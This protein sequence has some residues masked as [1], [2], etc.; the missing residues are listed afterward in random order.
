MARAQVYRGNPE[1]KQT[2]IFDN[3][4]GGINTTSIDEQV[5]TNEFRKLKNV[6][7]KE[8]GRIQNR[9]GFANVLGV[10]KNLDF[11][12]PNNKYY[13]LDIVEDTYNEIGKLLD[14]NYIMIGRITIDAVYVKN[15]NVHI[16]RYVIGNNEGTNTVLSEEDHLIVEGSETVIKEPK[17]TG[18]NVMN[19]D[20][21]NYFLINEILD[22]YEGFVEWGELDSEGK[23]IEPT[24]Y[25]KENSYMPNIYDVLGIGTNVFSNNPQLHISESNTS[26]QNIIYVNL[27]EY[28]NELNNIDKIPNNGKFTIEVYSTGT[29]IEEGLTLNFYH[30]VG[31]DKRPINAVISD[32]YKQNG[33]LYY[34]VELIDMPTDKLIFL[35]IKKEIEYDNIPEEYT[36]DKIDD[37][38]ETVRYEDSYYLLKTDKAKKYNAFATLWRKKKDTYFE[39]E[40]VMLNKLEY[41]ENSYNTDPVYDYT[42]LYFPDDSIPIMVDERGYQGYLSNASGR[43]LIDGSKL[44]YPTIGSINNM[45]FDVEAPTSEFVWN[46]TGNTVFVPDRAGVANLGTLYNTIKGENIFATA[47]EALSSPPSTSGLYSLITGYKWVGSTSIEYSNASYKIIKEGYFGLSVP[48]T[49]ADANRLVIPTAELQE[50]GGWGSV[51]L[52]IKNTTGTGE[53]FSF[54]KLTKVDETIGGNPKV[55][56]SIVNP[57]KKS[58]KAQWYTM[59]G[60]IYD[61]SP[62]DKTFLQLYTKNPSPAGS[63][64]SR[65]RIANTSYNDIYKYDM[66]NDSA[67]DHL[68]PSHHGR[69][70]IDGE[71]LL[72]IDNYKELDAYQRNIIEEIAPYFT[73]ETVLKIGEGEE[74][75]VYKFYKWN[76]GNEGS[77][78]AFDEIEDVSE[79]YVLFNYISSFDVGNPDVVTPESINLSNLKGIIIEDNLV[80][81]GKNTILWSEPYSNITDSSGTKQGFSYF[82]NR[83]WAALPLSMKDEIVKIAYYR[84]SYIIFTKESIYRL[85]GTLGD[86]NTMELVMINNEI[87]CVSP[88]SVRSINNTLI[89]LAETGLHQLK[90]SYYM[91]GL[92]NVAKVDGKIAGLIPYGTNYESI[93]YNNQYLLHIKDKDGNYTKTIKQYYNID[94]AGKH[95]P[96]V[97]DVYKQEPDLIFRMEEN[98]YSLK[99]GELYIYDIGYTDFFPD[100]DKENR[101]LTDYT[102]EVEIETPNWSLGYPVHEKKWKNVFLRVDSFQKFPINLTIAIDKVMSVSS[103]NYAAIL[104]AFGEIEYIRKED[105]NNLVD[106]F[107]AKEH[108]TIV[109]YEDLETLED[110]MELGEGELGVSVLG[111]RTYQIHKLN[112][113][114]KG[115]TIQFNFKIN[116]PNYFALDTLSIV[117]KLGKMRE[118][119]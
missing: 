90:Q 91:D 119:R 109:P 6:E 7:L 77:I 118:S 46:D 87:G 67:E 117:Y 85:S 41:E 101:D 105:I 69:L 23:L 60:I 15:N 47:Q 63:W 57:I 33:L 114:N 81:Y 34:D 92:E 75:I 32:P 8:E 28:Q 11:L 22:G 18:L 54:W 29:K 50:S 12:S 49:V 66:E 1:T 30:E 26:F 65:Y 88:D 40:Q 112:P 64:Y 44:S 86:P 98:M 39:T 20:G 70:L 89:F 71:S 96:Y 36:F 17:L 2:I 56:E 111:D 115:K 116:S 108:V 113:G 74:P 5:L 53:T 97:V 84:G 72:E 93:L 78:A 13:Y 24:H 76:G 55:Y 94:P 19:Y 104:N 35:E 48:H 103:E 3:F 25:N 37:L 100:E 14:P 38:L 61:N 62:E 42:S 31:E 43:R 79:N 102:Y 27:K 73:K 68:H 99:N 52:W 107:I 9:K 58:Y 80:L 59:L 83:N 51:V 82:S 10:N 16:T 45:E 110:I 21:K 95:N 4:S 106:P